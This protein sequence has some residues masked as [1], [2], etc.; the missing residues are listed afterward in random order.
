M[1]LLPVLFP[2]CP[3]DVPDLLLEGDP[4]MLPESDPLFEPVVPVPL[5][6]VAPVPLDP[7][8]PVPEPLPA[9]LVPPSAELLVPERDPA[10]GGLPGCEP[11]R[12]VLLPV[13]PVPPLLAPPVPLA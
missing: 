8:A 5:E 10:E 3:F 4:D 12:S 9:P 11:E 2:D 7:V 1:L 6:P 13:L